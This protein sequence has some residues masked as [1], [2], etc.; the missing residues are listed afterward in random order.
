MRRGISFI[1][2]F[3]ALAAAVAGLAACGSGSGSDAGGGSDAP[4]P[5][6]RPARHVQLPL[7][8]ASRE[9]VD[10]AGTRS[11]PTRALPTELYLPEG[12]GRHPLIVFAHGYDG[13]P[14]KFT[15]L[16]GAWQAAGFAVAAP[17]FPVTATGASA[18]PLAR[19]GDIAQQP[20]DLSF[21]LDR[22]LDGPYADRIDAKHIGA[23]GLSLGGGTVWG[24]TTDP[25]CRDRRI[26]AAVVM[27]G[28]QFGFGTESDA[29]NRI[30][31]LVYH[32]DR[33]YALPFSAARDAY[34]QA[35]TPKH[36]VTLFGFLHAE[37]YENTPSPVDDVVR[38][39][40]IAFWRAYLLGDD[41]AR[42]AITTTATAPGISTAESDT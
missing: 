23:A 38:R 35:R 14:T 29:P 5:T 32:A 30:P 26:A 18:G 15:E 9:A 16:F 33:D 6:P 17:R 11:A 10:P 27:D 8:D 4:E 19:A 2:T 25:C 34:A 12:S 37:P 39:S 3:G 24:L 1:V 13:D 31:I 7:V 28:N 22:L 41:A 21:V 42:E 20:A 40:S 36:F